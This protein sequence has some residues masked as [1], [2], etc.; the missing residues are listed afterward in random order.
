MEK[1]PEDGW[2]GTGSNL[3]ERIGLTRLFWFFLLLLVL[4]GQTA[5]LAEKEQYKVYQHYAANDEGSVYL[6]GYYFHVGV[7]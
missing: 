6:E 7:D 4:P 5:F 3:P 2:D 1:P